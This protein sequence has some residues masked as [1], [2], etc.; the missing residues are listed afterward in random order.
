M[1]IMICLPG[2]DFTGGFLDSFSQTLFHL[3]RAGHSVQ[4]SRAESSSVSH[5]RLQCLGVDQDSVDKA[6][7][8]GIEYD[9]ILWIDSDMHWKPEDAERLV[10]TAE[11]NGYSILSGCYLM[12]D[13]DHLTIA[14]GPNDFY[15]LQEIGE[16]DT[17][18][19]FYAGMGFMAIKRG[20]F[21]ALEYPY[22]RLLVIDGELYSEDASFCVLAREAGFLTHFE[23]TIYAN[24]EKRI[25]L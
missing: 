22:F 24:H 8:R 4:I 7:F 23:P 11:K 2:C 10:L 6:L 17:D 18:A 12:R 25:R 19:C 16:A 14:R 13:G 9:W 5:A 3:V 20:V 15:R 1:R 21:E